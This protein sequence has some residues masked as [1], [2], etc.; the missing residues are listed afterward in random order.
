MDIRKAFDHLSDLESSLNE[1]MGC[2]DCKV[3][4][5]PCDDENIWLNIRKSGLPDIDYLCNLVYGTWLTNDESIVVDEI[6][7]DWVAQHMK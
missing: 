6:V 5:I 7:Y 1:V 2:K 4:L 3:T